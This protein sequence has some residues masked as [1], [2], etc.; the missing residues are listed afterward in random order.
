MRQSAWSLLKA[1]IENGADSSVHDCKALV[2][3]AERVMYCYARPSQKVVGTIT[4]FTYDIQRVWVKWD[5]GKLEVRSLKSL[6]LI[7]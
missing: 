7:K 2:L 4:A 6:E 5:D 1:A 3:L